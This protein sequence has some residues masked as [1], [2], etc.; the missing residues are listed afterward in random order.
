MSDV[1]CGRDGVS[2]TRKFETAIEFFQR[3]LSRVDDEDDDDEVEKARD[4][5]EFVRVLSKNKQI[6]TRVRARGRQFRGIEDDVSE[7]VV[8]S[9]G[10]FGEDARV[11]ASERSVG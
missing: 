4:S 3:A 11:S 1:E 6:Q 8:S 9:R 7:G 2:R 5:R 10:S